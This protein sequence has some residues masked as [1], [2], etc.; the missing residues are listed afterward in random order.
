MYELE[1]QGD[2]IK[3]NRKSVTEGN[4]AI[5]RE[6]R[7][8][9]TTFSRKSRKRLCELFNRLDLKG[10]KT[11][12]LTLTFA[13]INMAD[14][15]TQAFKRFYE[16]LRYHFPSVSFVWRKELQDRGA[17]HYH[18]LVWNLPFISQ[19]QLQDVWTQCTGEPL[20]ILDIRLIRGKKWVIRYV[21]KYLAKVPTSDESG[22]F[23]A[24]PY[25]QNGEKKT[26]GRWWGIFNKS[27]IPY[28]PLRKIKVKN[29]GAL[30]YLKFT[31]K[32]LSANKC[33]NRTLASVLFHEDAEKLFHKF[34]EME[35]MIEV[36]T[37]NI[38][39]WIDSNSL[40]G[41]TA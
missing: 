39:Q 22:S 9:V 37:P 38:R 41:M 27:F 31:M 8:N 40:F 10:R 14:T 24:P 4:D 17:F 28:A 16:R 7:G 12:F 5:K 23:I 29:V 19:K 26:S 1:Q 21:S 6:K 20:S 25:L 34:S 32:R 2:V 11:I 35:H 15:A 30:F 3:I 13:K 36:H 33:S 18:L